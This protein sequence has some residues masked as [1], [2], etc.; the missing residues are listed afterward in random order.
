M[1]EPRERIL[2]KAIKWKP[3]SGKRGVYSSPEGFDDAWK[4]GRPIQ[5]YLEREKYKVHVYYRI[6]HGKIEFPPSEAGRYG[7]LREIYFM[8]S[9]F[10]D[11]PFGPLDSVKQE[12]AVV[13]HAFV[14]CAEW[15]DVVS[16]KLGEIGEQPN[17]ADIAKKLF[18]YLSVVPVYQ[19]MKN[20]VFKPKSYSRGCK[21]SELSVSDMVTLGV[22]HSF[23]SLGLSHKELAVKGE[24]DQK[25]TPYR[26]LWTE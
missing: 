21:G 6:I 14:N 24:Y 23:F 7:T 5:F 9:E 13:A 20:K 18:P 15:H 1:K 12:S 11:S 3:P 19:W 16:G 25:K 4:D 17:I 10:L 26:F 8:P 2:E 22:L